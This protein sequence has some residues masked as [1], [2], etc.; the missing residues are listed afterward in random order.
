MKYP[1]LEEIKTSRTMVDTFRGYNHNLR[2]SENEFY[3]MENLTSNHYP[4]LSPRS[5]RG[6]AIPDITPQAMI[7][8]DSLCYIDG[9]YFVMNEYRVDMGLSEGEKQLVSMGACVI[10]LPDKKYINTA[11]LSDYGSIEASVTTSQPVTFQMCNIEGA[12]YDNI[13]DPSETEP[14]NPVNG[15]YWI[16]SST[17]PH[18]LKQYSTSAEMWVSVPTSYIKITS[19]GI[20]A[21]FEKYDGVNISGLKDTSLVT[22]DG[23]SVE[24]NGINAID[25]SY[26]IWERGDNYIVIVGFIDAAITIGNTIT[27]TRQMPKMDFIIESGNRLWGCRYGTAINGDVVNE[28]YASK[29]GDFKNWNCF[30]GL[31]TDSYAVSCGTDGQFTG[32]ITHLGLPI[33]FKENCM[34][35]VYGN[36]PS[37][38]QIQTTACDGVQKGSHKSLAI[39]NGTLYFK[40]RSAVCGYDGSLP[41]GISTALGDVS[42]TEAVA[43]GHA[44]KYYISMKDTDGRWHLFVYDTKK[45]LWHREDNLHVKEFC[46]CR[47]DLYYTEDG[48]TDIRTMLGS[49]T[50]DSDPVKWLAETGVIGVTSPDKKYVSRMNLRLSLNVGTRIRLFVQYD[51]NDEWEI[52]QEIVGTRLRTFT[53][54]IR[55]RRC[56]HLRL[57]IVGEG[58]AKIYSITKI[59]PI[60]I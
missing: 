41:A 44:Y 52:I 28:I 9:S 34:H 4:V 2:I 29:L 13:G 47:D 35:K 7:A 51:S 26:A 36:F 25:G 3:D 12:P 15:Q 30:M 8:K 55:P 19:A 14:S 33:F 40:S 21:A 59:S 18:T 53:I 49:G 58:E 57:R 56:D 43:C 46:S 38:F 42:Y 39:V 5:A 1:T 10:I 16:D 23:D 32:A 37:N 60:D 45:G 54:P 31:S 24:N 6:T 27:V 22:P 48:R 20:G 17:K 50:K 11:D